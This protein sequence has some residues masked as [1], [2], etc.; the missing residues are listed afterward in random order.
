MSEN[1]TLGFDSIN[2]YQ[3]EWRCTKNLSAVKLTN[4]VDGFASAV[5][6]LED[7]WPALSLVD[8]SSGLPNTFYFDPRPPGSW[9]VVRGTEAVQLSADGA[10][11]LTRLAS[12]KE[13]FP[14]LA[15][16]PREDVDFTSGFDSMN[17]CSDGWWFTNGP[18]LAKLSDDF[19]GIKAPPTALTDPALFPIFVDTD[20]ASGVDT[21]YSTTDGWWTT[22]GSLIAQVALSR[23]G[24][25][26]LATQLSDRLR[27]IVFVQPGSY[28]VDNTAPIPDGTPEVTIEMWGP[29]GD[30]G[31]S[32]GEPNS[33][34]GDG[35]AGA[36]LKETFPF[37]PNSQFKLHVGGSGDC[38]YYGGSVEDSIL[39]AAGGGGGGGAGGFGYGNGWGGR[40]WGWRRLHQRRPAGRRGR[41]CWPKRVRRQRQWW[42]WW[43]SRI[44]RCWRCRRTG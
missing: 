33:C 41:Q 7:W 26:V 17:L 42:W 10:T 20:W 32:V 39:V 6:A 28:V 3:G 30:G 14:G 11:V 34:G 8:F 31:Q 29:G 12:L 15:L 21:L 5:V 9:W 35:G 24:W 27:S 18:W 19:S 38:T 13:I 16:L 36:Y 43:Q 2:Q 40:R 37:T 23:T 44:R 25:N 4:A 22:K 1:W